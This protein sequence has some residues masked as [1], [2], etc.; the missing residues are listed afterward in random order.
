MS[1]QDD[2]FRSLFLALVLK[3]LP[4]ILDTAGLK[5]KASH[6]LRVTCEARLFH[7]CV[8]ESLIREHTGHRLSALHGYEKKS[9]EQ[10]RNVGF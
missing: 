3:S 1:I 9:E 2:V 8:P 7:E 10:E 5:R 4:D 6:S